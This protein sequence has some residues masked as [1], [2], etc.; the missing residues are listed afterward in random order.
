MDAVLAAID[1]ARREAGFCTL[2]E[3]AALARSCRILDPFSTLI[4]RALEIAAGNVLYPGVVLQADPG[5]QVVIG[6]QNIFWPGAAVVARAGR[7][8]IGARNEFGPGGAT[9]YLESDARIAIGD[10]G[11][12]RDG[13]AIGAGCRL[14][15]GAQVLGAVQAQDCELGDGG[16]HAEPDPD[17]RGGV[18][19]GNGRA[20]GL[21]VDQGMVILGEGRFERADLRPQSYFHPTGGAG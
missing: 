2:D 5:A 18:L 19:K 8:V 21:K 6:R 13:A 4:S 1:A 12:Y 14:G 11:R 15:N 17:R 10:D 20:R 3:L 9:V 7:I 16:S